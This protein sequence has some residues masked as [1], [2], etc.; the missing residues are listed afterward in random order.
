M[1]SFNFAAKSFRGFHFC[2][3]K[4]DMKRFSQNLNKHA[5]CFPKMIGKLFSAK[6]NKTKSVLHI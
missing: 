6:R 2:W 4:R 1:E 5:D 3:N